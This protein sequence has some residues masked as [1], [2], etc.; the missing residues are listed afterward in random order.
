MK[1]P[2]KTRGDILRYDQQ[3]AEHSLSGENN[4]GLLHK[5]FALTSLANIQ[6]FGP[7][8]IAR[9]QKNIPTSLALLHGCRVVLDCGT[10][11]KCREIFSWLNQSGCFFERSAATH[12]SKMDGPNKDKAQEVKV[13]W[14]LSGLGGIKYMLQNALHKLPI[15][16]R[17]IPKPKTPHYG[18]NVGISSFN[19]KSWDRNQPNGEHGHVY[20]NFN[21]DKSILVFGIEETA[22]G[23]PGHEWWRLGKANPLAA[24]GGPK[25]EDLHKYG[26]EGFDK[27]NSM[28]GKVGQISIAQLNE[29][30]SLPPTALSLLMCSTTPDT[31]ME[32]TQNFKKTKPLKSKTFDITPNTSPRPPKQTKSKEL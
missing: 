21:P 4:N 2:E 27:Y 3:C 25:R 5:L 14:I 26:F 6:T 7:N 24:S 12:G 28:C 15:I 19:G 23:L 8:G 29:V 16:G 9:T 13:H 20:C 18:A 31:I 30:A 10:P 22:P 11:E 17:L 32:Q 1:D